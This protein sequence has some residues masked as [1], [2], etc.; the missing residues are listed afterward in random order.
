MFKPNGEL[1]D[2]IIIF[3]SPAFMEASH[4][5]FLPSIDIYSIL[6]EFLNKFK[7]QK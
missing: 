1:E 7:A 6:S 3:S 4:I 2:K 5:F